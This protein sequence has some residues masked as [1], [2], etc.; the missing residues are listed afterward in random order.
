[1]KKLSIIL[2]STFLIFLSFGINN[3]QKK[4]QAEPDYK[5]TLSSV[6]IFTY[7]KKLIEPTVFSYTNL[8]DFIQLVNNSIDI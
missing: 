1:M 7:L 2:F 6:G 8:N 4:S 3:S 5:F